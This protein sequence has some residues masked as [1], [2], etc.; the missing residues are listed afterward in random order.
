MSKASDSEDNEEVEESK[1]EE[2]PVDSDDEYSDVN[3]D[4]YGDF[5]MMAAIMTLTMRRLL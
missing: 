2:Y 3:K 1:S 5:M 4:Y